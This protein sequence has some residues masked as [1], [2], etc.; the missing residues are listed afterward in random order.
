MSQ[1]SVVPPAPGISS[2]IWYPTVAHFASSP[3]G[4]TTPALSRTMGDFVLGC[5]GMLGNPAATI[6]TDQAIC[7]GD[8][9]CAVSPVP[10]RSVYRYSALGASA[11]QRSCGVRTITASSIVEAGRPRQRFRSNCRPASSASHPAAVSPDTCAHGRQMERPIAGAQTPEDCSGSGPGWTSVPLPVRVQSPV[12]SS[13]WTFRRVNHAVST[14]RAQSGAGGDDHHAPQGDN[15]PQAAEPGRALREGGGAGPLTA[16]QRPPLLI[17]DPL[18]TV[19][20]PLLLD[21][22]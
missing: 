7:D 13:I 16:Q 22:G 19:Q 3:L 20:P 10:V 17:E 9:E 5:A 21:R 11:R 8:L 6:V 14:H 2:R 12:P 1:G 4:G 15:S 18:V